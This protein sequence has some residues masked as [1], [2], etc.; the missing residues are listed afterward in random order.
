MKAIPGISWS[1]LTDAF[2]DPTSD[3]LHGLKSHGLHALA[4]K[5]LKV[6]FDGNSRLLLK[7]QH[8]GIDLDLHQRE[9][10]GHRRDGFVIHIAL[11]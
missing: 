9:R 2:I 6:L 3:S 10:S 1:L 4:D 11:L 7:Q 8:E 5:S